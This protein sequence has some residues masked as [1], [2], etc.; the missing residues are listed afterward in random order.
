MSDE[1]SRNITEKK[2]WSAGG[3]RL[4]FLTV[5][6]WLA[7][8]GCGSDDVR[9]SPD[10][11]LDTVTIPD[12]SIL[13]YVRVDSAALL[14][15]DLVLGRTADLGEVFPA[16]NLFVE[17]LPVDMLSKVAKV[18][19]QGT[20]VNLVF[21]DPAVFGGGA[22]LHFVPKK[23]GNLV[24]LLDSDPG[25]V[26]TGKSPPEFRMKRETFPLREFITSLRTWGISLEVPGTD[27]DQHFLV[28]ED[29]SGV[30]VLPCFDVRRDLK[31][32]FEST[33]Y[34]S[35]WGDATCVVDLDIKRLSDAYMSVLRSLDSS[36]R[37]KAAVLDILDRGEHLLKEGKQLRLI[38]TTIFG[39]L[40][41]IDGIRFVSRSPVTGG[42]ELC[43]VAT[44][45]GCLDQLFRVLQTGEGDLIG[46]MS[47]GL[48]L[49]LN[50]G[51][52][53]LK[54]LLRKTA[55]FYANDVELEPGSFDPLMDAVDQSF[56]FDAGRYLVG[57]GISKEEEWLISLS[58]L[59]DGADR[60]ARGSAQERTWQCMAELLG[61]TIE[62][63][64]LPGRRKIVHYTTPSSN[65]LN[66]ESG[67]D[68]NFHLSTILFGETT[69]P[70]ELTGRL[71]RLAGYGVPRPRGL[72]EKAPLYFR[73]SLLPLFDLS[74]S[75]MEKFLFS[76]LVG[77]GRIEGRA[78]TIDFALQ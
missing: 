18:V 55:G 53:A 6:L 21:L 63:H 13:G 16:A 39:F 50:A 48:A 35:P 69:K 25:Y 60:D 71:L 76:E 44:D 54:R 28:E 36:L 78:L 26:R 47:G 52:N 11:I 77:S 9:S 49:Q 58:V 5:S 4:L 22:A 38:S 68:K 74:L 40:A 70:G 2:P 57:A 73:F 72:P 14:G 29:E 3:E 20:H 8:L 42:A 19:K 1:R 24:R 33:D 34:L 15:V 10:E 23:R 62:A 32:F 27:R 46:L 41:G 37:K 31:A 17:S 43:I 45:G 75:A 7:L 59:T 66:F 65:V 12:P 56:S 67:L 30:L 51:P 64:P 61:S